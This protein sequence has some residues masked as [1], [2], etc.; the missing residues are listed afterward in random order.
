MTAAWPIDVPPPGVDEDAEMLHALELERRRKAGQ[1]EA[2]KPPAPWEP[3]H[4]IARDL[5]RALPESGRGVDYW[6]T[7]RMVRERHGCDLFV[8]QQ[9]ALGLVLVE[10]AY[11]SPGPTGES[12]WI[13]RGNDPR[14]GA[15]TIRTG[16]LG[17]MGG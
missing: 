17:G 10:K 14:T 2:P 16:A 9:A 6:R 5:W 4:P 12:S 7:L 15:A 8:V 1:V 13:G 11:V 3:S